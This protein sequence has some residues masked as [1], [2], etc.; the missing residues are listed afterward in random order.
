MAVMIDSKSAELRH[1]RGV[2]YDARGERPKA[3]QDFDQATKLGFREQNPAASMT[4]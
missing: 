2:V 4:R 1:Q 3:Q